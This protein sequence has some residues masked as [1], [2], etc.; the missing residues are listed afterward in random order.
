[1][2]MITGSFSMEIIMVVSEEKKGKKNK[3]QIDLSV[4]LLGSYPK[5]S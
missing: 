1:M 3:P 2:G 5:N 4:Q